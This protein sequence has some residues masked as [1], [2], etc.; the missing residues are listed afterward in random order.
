MVSIKK[1]LNLPLRGAPQQKVDE[2]RTTKTV[3][4]VGSNYKGMKPTMLVNVGDEVKIGQKCFEDKKNPGVFFTAPGAGK[5]VELNRGQ[6]RTFQSLVIELSSNE[7][8]QSFSSYSSKDIDGW[9][10][11]GIRELLIESGM[12]TALRTR[13]FS[14]T[15]QVDSSASAIFINAMDTN[16]LAL[17]PSYV[18]SLHRENFQNGVKIISKLTEGKTFVC[19]AAGKDIGL[20]PQGSIKIED[21]SGPHPAGNVGTHIHF[22]HPVNANRSVWHI[23]YQDVIAIGHLFQ[24]GQLSLERYV[25]LSGP[26]V[27]QPRILKTRLGA[28]C[29]E[30]VDD[31]LISGDSRIISGSVFSGTKCWG[32]FSYLGRFD[33]QIT[34]VEEGRDREF[35]GWHA[36]GAKKFSIK[37]VFVSALTGLSKVKI[38]TNKNGSY[39]AM[40]PIG[41]YEKV[42]PMDILP[43]QL[44]KA[45]ITKNTDQAQALGALELDEE[46][47]ALMTFADPGKVDFGPILR[48]NLNI[49]EKEG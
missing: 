22:L 16:P 9:E 40:V 41:I 32:P 12:W 13:P 39:R 33:N 37:P 24:T 6:K 27:K 26:L 34:V 20:N 3:A 11:Q 38:T 48:E 5:V 14:K 28:N 8:H 18:I 43:T 30:L 1:G 46:D 42:M 45:L 17:D 49:I 47:I 23:G 21:F 25:A 35:L 10:A 7:E 29:M 15:P 36:P 4:L 44:L 31:Q 19:K 2:T